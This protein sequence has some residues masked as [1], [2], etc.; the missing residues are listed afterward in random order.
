[1]IIND[2]LGVIGVVV[3]V[4]IFILVRRDKLHI[5]HGIGWI[6]IAIGFFFL[7]LAPQVVNK[8]ARILD[9]GYPPVIALSAA[10]IALTIKIFAMDLE[11]SRSLVREERL[12]QQLAILEAQISNQDTPGTSE[13]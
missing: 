13:E 1:M 7:G 5:G 9:V 11:R 6:V 4:S 12:I 10:I 2:I 8:L 3:A